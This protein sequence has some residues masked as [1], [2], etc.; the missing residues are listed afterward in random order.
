MKTILSSSFAI[1]LLLTSIAPPEKVR[2]QTPVPGID[3]APLFESEEVLRLTL[4]TDIRP[5]LRNRDEEE[6][7]EYATISYAESDGTVITQDI[8]VR[9]RGIFRRMKINCN[10]PPLRLNFSKK[11]AEGTLF[12]GQDKVKLVTHCRENEQ[13]YEQFVLLEYLIYRMYNQLTDLSFKVRLV[14]MTYEDSS[15]KRKPSTRNGFLIEDDDAMAERNKG[16]ILR[17]QGH[18]EEGT[19]FNQ[20]T[21]FALFQYMVGNSD[22]QVRSLH[23]IRLVQIEGLL[24]PFP[25][26]YDFDFAGLVNTPYA[27]PKRTLPIKNVRDRYYEG[28][29]RTE[30][31]LASQLSVFLDQKA[32]IYAL[33]EDLEPLSKRYR[34]SAIGYLNEFYGIIENPKRVRRA[35]IKSCKKL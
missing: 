2:G 32:A 27:S 9:T 30:E 12:E 11:G 20:I 24:L 33:F 34:K 4:K 15:G 26:P 31:Q 8:K 14:E 28:H 25:V 1:L 7:Q 29:C 6:E 16:I 21:L 10:F 5:L 19:D 3:P 13:A 35:F 23:N 22:W 18:Q 17:Q